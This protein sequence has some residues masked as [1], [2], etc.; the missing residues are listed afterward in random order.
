MTDNLL[1]ASDDPL[2]RAA[3]ALRRAVVP[4]GPPDET[5]SRTLAALHA[6]NETKT[7]PFYRRNPMR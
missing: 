6:A 4:E 3:D 7:V 2:D 1:P 5:V